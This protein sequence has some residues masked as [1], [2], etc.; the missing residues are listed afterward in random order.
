MYLYLWIFG[1]WIPLK[2][3]LNG[4]DRCCGL[5]LVLGVSGRERTQQQS[6]P[7][8][9]QCAVDPVDQMSRQRLHPL[10][11]RLPHLLAGGDQGW[12]PAQVEQSL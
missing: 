12:Q 4:V 11:H 7:R 6:F 5:V 8:I 9:A 1:S 10:S 2:M 3:V